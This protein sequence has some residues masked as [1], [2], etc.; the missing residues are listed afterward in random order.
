MIYIIRK[1]LNEMEYLPKT[2]FTV[3][4]E[5]ENELESRQIDMYPFVSTHENGTCILVCYID[6]KNFLDIDDKELII[7]MASG[8]RTCE[9]YEPEM[10]KNTS[11]IICV[12]RNQNAS[13]SVDK[14]RRLED[15]PFYFKK[16]VLIHSEDEIQELNLYLKGSDD[17]LDTLKRYI[18]DKDHFNS[19]KSE[20]EN[21]QLYSVIT[22]LTTKIPIL[23]LDASKS[24]DLLDV[25]SHFSEKYDREYTAAKRTNIERIIDAINKYPDDETQNIE[26]LIDF[27]RGLAAI[28]EGSGI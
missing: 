10:D 14:Q 25:A 26:R 20:P 22:N 21:N 7:N 15:D 4:Y 5:F 19:Y 2:S 6:E 12:K 27:S 28:F 18:Y 17:F 9:C 3:N 24:Y 8:F 23:P 16:Y 13:V 11:L 1:L